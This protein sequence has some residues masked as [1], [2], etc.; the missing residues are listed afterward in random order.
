M[1]NHMFNL[2]ISFGGKS[3]MLRTIKQGSNIFVQG[4][5]VRAL[6]DGRITVRVGDL[7]Y[8]GQPVKAAA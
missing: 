2:S 3:G 1:F 5:F 8:C 4:M 6:P 7:V